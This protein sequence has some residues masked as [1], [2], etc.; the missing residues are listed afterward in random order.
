MP[1]LRI[2]ALTLIL[3]PLLAGCSETPE[4]PKNLLLIGLD[5]VR[6]DAFLLPEQAGNTDALSD[7]LKQAL[8]FTRAHSSSSWTAPAVASLLTGLY[9]AHH[10]AGRFEQ[11]VANLTENAF[12]PLAERYETLTERLQ[13]QGF[14]TVLITSHPMLKGGHGLAQGFDKTHVRKGDDKLVRLARTWLE[15]KPMQPFFLYVHLMAA[16][17]WH[18]RTE[19]FDELLDTF[20]PQ[21]K[22]AARQ[23]A[24]GNVCSNQTSHLCR[25][26]LVYSAAIAKQRRLVAGLLDTLRQQG[27]LDSTLVVLYADHGEEFNEHVAIEREWGVDPRNF[28]G[29]G[30][31][32]SLFQELLHVPLVVWHPDLPGQAATK[33]VSLVDIAPAILNWFGLEAPGASFDGESINDLQRDEA[34]PFAWSNYEATA[35]PDMERKIFASGIAYGPEQIAVLTD[36]WKYLWHEATGA[37]ALFN[38]REDPH[39]HKSQS[40]ADIV[41]RLEPALDRYFQWLSANKTEAANLSDEQIQEL[42]GVGYLQ[43]ADSATQ[44]GEENEQRRSRPGA[45]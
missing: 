25:R 40:N 2:C 7:D 17:E 45:R 16:H 23:Y 35:W 9:P 32:Q 4:P 20:A 12:S 15:K 24:P 1:N 42:K 44:G 36:G 6:F 43:G 30:H 27:L 10:G 11:P 39:E 33:V 3:A 29:T 38:L 37:S 18:A 31:G 41:S 19:Q 21:F 34:P 5:T 14:N 22:Q 13:E 26:W 8:I 28:Y